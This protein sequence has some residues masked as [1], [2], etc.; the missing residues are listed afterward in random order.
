MKDFNIC[1]NWNM[2]NLSFTSLQ[3][4]SLRSVAVNIL[5]YFISYSTCYFCVITWLMINNVYMNYRNTNA[6]MV[7]KFNLQVICSSGFIPPSSEFL[8]MFPLWLESLYYWHT[9]CLFTSQ[10]HRHGTEITPEA[11]RSLPLSAPAL[12]QGFSPLKGTKVTAN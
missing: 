10:L 8:L 9:R 1:T 4:R 11:P 2:L 3:L 5:F 6:Q 12:L 7:S